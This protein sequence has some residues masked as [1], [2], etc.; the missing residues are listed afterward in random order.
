MFATFCDFAAHKLLALFLHPLT[1]KKRQ[2]G[3][4]GQLAV[5]PAPKTPGPSGECASVKTP[6][7]R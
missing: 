1:K 5:L 3:G 7:T 4:S 2:V 6:D